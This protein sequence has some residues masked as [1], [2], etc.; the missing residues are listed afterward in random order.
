M[1]SELVNFLQGLD[2]NTQEDNDTLARGTLNESTKDVTT[3]PIVGHIVTREEGPYFPSA[4]YDVVG[5]VQTSEGDKIYIT[6]QWY[7]EH[8]RIP[9]LIPAMMVKQYTPAE[10]EATDESEETQDKLEQNKPFPVTFGLG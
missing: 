5:I 1:Y 10:Q 9:L 6:N 3:A 8:K 4:K 2:D 7:K